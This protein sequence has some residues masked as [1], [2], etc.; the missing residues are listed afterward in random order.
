[1]LAMVCDALEVVVS[2]QDGHYAATPCESI[3]PPSL[4][5]KGLDFID[6]FCQNLGDRHFLASFVQ[7]KTG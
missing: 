2:L 4:Q 6:F 1:M 7:H 3:T 5:K